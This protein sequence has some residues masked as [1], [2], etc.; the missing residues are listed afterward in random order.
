LDNRRPDTLATSISIRKTMQD[1]TLTLTLDEVNGIL[2][3]MAKT[4]TGSGYFPL[5][6]KVKEQ[7]E[8][9]LPA[10]TQQ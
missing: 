4:E 6:L 10:P 1:I 3:L 8:A 2:N 7:A 5:M 9:Q